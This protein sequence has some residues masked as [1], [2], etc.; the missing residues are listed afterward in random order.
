MQ[1]FDAIYE[2]V[3]KFVCLEFSIQNCELL[4]LWRLP[5][6]KVQEQIQRV[7]ASQIYLFQVKFG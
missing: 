3:E 1:L 7:L 5:G 6:N 2:L 4:K